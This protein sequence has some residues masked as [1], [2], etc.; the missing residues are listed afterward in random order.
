MTTRSRSTSPSPMMVLTSVIL[1]IERSGPADCR[2][3]AR[4]PSPESPRTRRTLV[5]ASESALR[6]AAHD[7]PAEVASGRLQAPEAIA[8]QGRPLN[9]RVPAR[10]PLTVRYEGSPACSARA[11]AA[12]SRGVSVPLAQP[13]HPLGPARPKSAFTPATRDQRS[14][15]EPTDLTMMRRDLP[16]N[17]GCRSRVSVA[18]PLPGHRP[19]LLGR[20]RRAARYQ[21]RHL[22]RMHVLAH[23]CSKISATS[24]TVNVLLAI[25]GRSVPVWMEDKAQLEGPRRGTAAAILVDRDTLIEPVGNYLI[26]AGAQLGNSLI[27]SSVAHYADLAHRHA[28]GR[29]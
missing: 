18:E 22:R 3:S 10:I 17:D 14:Q 11:E 5:Q 26:A 1:P 6:Q 27:V 16:P 13:Q 4:I 23:Q 7:L 15:A 2:F 19:P 20:D 9:P 24:I 8:G 29:W 28:A 12:S 25:S 21:P